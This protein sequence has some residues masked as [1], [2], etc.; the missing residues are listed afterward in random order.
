MAEAPDWLHELLGWKS[1]TAKSSATC[2]NLFGE[3]I[4]PNL[5]DVGSKTSMRFAG[6]VYDM[7][8]IPRSQRAG[9]ADSEASG[10][11]LEKA[12]ESNLRGSLDSSDPGRTWIVSRTGSV[13]DYAQFTHLSSLQQIIQ[14]NSTLRA[15]FAGD[16]QVKTDV[17]VGVE[18]PSDPFQPPFLHAA[19]SSKWTIRSDRVQNVR[20]EF[21]TLVKSRRGRCPHLVLVTAEPLPS[22]LLSIARGTGEVDSVYHL[23]YDEL[24]MAVSSICTRK[25][26]YLEQ[27]AAWHEMID[28][29]RLR[30]Y[31]ALVDDLILS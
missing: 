27:Q 10:T 22:R 15:T 16:Y 2:T 9:D 28:Q 5:S 1:A 11:A 12:I 23:L 31:S 17:Y 4:A 6:F 29:K 30:P 21:A 24:D 20:H 3:P 7:L 18:N 14:T 25:G 19:I 13:A 8:D 26:D